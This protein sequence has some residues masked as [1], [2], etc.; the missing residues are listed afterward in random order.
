MRKVLAVLAVAAVLPT[1]AFAQQQLPKQTLS[2]FLSDVGRSNNFVNPWPGGVG[3]SFEQMLADRL[4]LHGSVAYERHRTITNAASRHLH[5]L[6]IDLTARYHWLNDTRWKPYLGL[7]LHYLAEPDV[8]PSFRYYRH[9]NGEL[10]GG[11][12]FML[13]RSFGLLLDG[14]AI[15]SRTEPF[16]SNLR[17]SAGVSWRF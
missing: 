1:I 16:D 14:K 11:V 7:G 10:D 15:V 3:V 8:D 4:S 9:V 5:T 13:N 17:L 6:P 2:V 12:V